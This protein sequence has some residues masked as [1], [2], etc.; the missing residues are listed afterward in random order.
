MATCQNCQMAL[1]P[2]A[3]FCSGCGSAVTEAARPAT[4]STN[5]N[6]EACGAPLAPN[7]RF[8]GSCGVSRPAASE[9]GYQAPFAQSAP[10]SIAPSSAPTVA[11]RSSAAPQKAPEPD[12]V[13][14]REIVEKRIAAKK[15]KLRKVLLMMPFSLAIWGVF[16]FIFFGKG[17]SSVEGNFTASGKPLGAVNLQPVKC[18]SG[19]HRGF[20]GVFILPEKPNQGGIKLIID[21]LKGPVVQVELPGSCKPPDLEQC[22]VVTLDKSACK[23]YSASVK[24]T[25][26]R[27]NRITLLD[28]RLNLDC[29]FKEGGTA[30]ANL[31]FESCD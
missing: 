27:V 16:F 24:R 31:K 13:A 9:Q 30:Q 20:H 8:C 18:K 14:Q 4:A 21:P 3:R 15:K 29:T 12:P 19:Q 26:T 23:T 25:N 7:S 5:T 17:C 2:N 10:S 22:T 1:A 11:Q 6:C 28:G